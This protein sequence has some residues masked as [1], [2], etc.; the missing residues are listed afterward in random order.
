MRTTTTRLAVTAAVTVAGLAAGSG[1]AGAAT[2]P[3]RTAPEQKGCATGAL[4]PAIQGAPAVKAG[5]ARGFY[6]GHDAHGYVLRVTK[7]LHDK[8]VLAGT[9]VASAAIRDTPRRLEK[10]DHVSLSA[11]RRVLS[12][13]FTNYGRI[14]GIN[15]AASCANSLT[16][17]FQ[18]SGKPAPASEV[19]LGK[20]RTSPETSTFTITRAP[21]PTDAPV[22]VTPAPAPAS[23][24]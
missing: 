24:A 13:R 23:N 4:P 6:V 3:H 9:I 12:F 5:S 11:D 21:K 15:F 8:A 1:V 20:G 19:H 2:A 17:S 16:F 14:D 7:P 22:P 10:A 18:D